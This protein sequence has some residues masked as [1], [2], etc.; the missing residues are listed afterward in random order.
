VLDV[1][2]VLVSNPIAAQAILPRC[3]CESF[4]PPRSS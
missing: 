1:H 4:V 3:D 2:V